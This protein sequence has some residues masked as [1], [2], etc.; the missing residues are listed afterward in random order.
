MNED[1]LNN[2]YKE[3]LR[4]SYKGLIH[5]V[6]TLILRGLSGAKVTRPGQFRSYE[7]GYGV[8]SSLGDDDGVLYPLENGFFFLPVPPTLIIMDEVNYVEIQRRGYGG[9]SMHYFDLLVKLKSEQELVFLDIRRSEY[10]NLI[11]FI[12]EK[13]LKIHNFGGE[14]ADGAPPSHLERIREIA[15]GS[16]DKVDLTYV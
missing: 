6:F 5:E 11:M 14:T 7:N 4:A 9:T 8:I 16:D 10:D 12:S 13:G 3:K 1:L 2:K 15:D